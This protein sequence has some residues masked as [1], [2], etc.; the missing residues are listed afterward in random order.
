MELI[1][2]KEIDQLVEYR[3]DYCVSIYLPTHIRGKEVLNK[4]DQHHLK[5]LWNECKEKLELRGADA[6]TIEKIAKPIQGLINDKNFWRHQ[7]QGLA[8]FAAP[9]FF[10]HKSLPINFETN[11]YI[12]DHFY[13]R[14]LAPILSTDQK[15]Y[16]LALQLDEVKLYEASEYSISEIKVNDLVPE[17]LNDVVGYDY[18]EKHLEMRNQQQHVAGGQMFHGHGGANR[19]NNKEILKF[20]Q[21]V[22]SGLNDYLN[23]KRNPLVVFCQDYLFPIYQEANNYSNL[24]EKPIAGNPN[25]VDV[26][27]LHERALDLLE[28]HFKANKEK[29]MHQYQEADPSMKSDAAHDLIPFAFE[30]KIDTLFLENRAELWGKYDQGIQKVSVHEKRKADN[31]SLM[32]LAARQVLKNDGK[33]YLIDSAFMPSKKSRMNA[34][35]RYN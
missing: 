31:R 28:D 3:S 21:A 19:N 8:I 27:G 24:Y 13:V 22:D 15:F 2:E 23:T 10:E 16:V 5:S 32:N 18:Q 20:F 12:A 11:I 30:G 14:S 33:V 26:L 17:N 35:L 9:D 25:D 4:E 29:K 34:I 7:S 6:K 1:L